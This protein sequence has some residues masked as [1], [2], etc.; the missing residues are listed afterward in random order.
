MRGP[1]P[2]T[3]QAAGL[4]VGVTCLRMPVSLADANAIIECAG[5]SDWRTPFLYGLGTVAVVGALLL[6]T[7]GVVRTAS[8]A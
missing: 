3:P 8:H 7:W 2:R 6:L 5:G 1:L 4:V